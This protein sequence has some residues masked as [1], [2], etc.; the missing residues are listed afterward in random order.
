MIGGVAG[1]PG[2]WGQ[3]RESEPQAGGSDPESRAPLAQPSA[4][5]TAP[6]GHPD[7]EDSGADEPDEQC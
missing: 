1:T 5:A 7:E 3:P 6:E 4:E 2:Q